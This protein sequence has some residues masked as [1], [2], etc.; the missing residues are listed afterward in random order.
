MKKLMLIVL[1]VLVSAGWAFEDNLVCYDQEMAC[2]LECIE[3]PES[4]KDSCIDD[5]QE[6]LKKCLKKVEDENKGGE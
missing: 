3:G 5:C 2:R 6:A 1:L 4:K